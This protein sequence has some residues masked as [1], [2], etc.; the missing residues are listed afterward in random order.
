MPRRSALRLA[1][2]A[3]CA[4]SW[5]A[6]AAWRGGYGI[7]PPAPLTDRV[8]APRDLQVLDGDTYRIDGRDMRLLGADTPEKGAPWF[9][10]DQEPWATRA[11]DF[12]R[13]RLRAASRIELRTHGKTDTF[14]RT[15]AH[16][17]I[18]GEP[19]AALLVEEGLA[20]PTVKR[21]GE[22]GFPRL[23][24][25]IVRRAR[26]APF[27]PPWEWRREHRQRGRSK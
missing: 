21:F 19:L 18:D 20:Y 7:T 6:V 4:L 14:G 17:L 8:L 1:V 23:A 13:A 9:R 26:P 11:T 22:G 16:V 10:G 2:L 25:E 15:L 3:T 27:P 5:V 24:A 12:A